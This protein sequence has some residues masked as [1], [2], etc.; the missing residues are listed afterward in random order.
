MKTAVHFTDNY[1]INPTNPILVNL[2]GVGGTGSQVLSAL[3]R[4]NVSLVKLGHPGLFVRAFDDDTITPANMGRQLFTES[5]IGLYKSV[6]IINRL[7]RF[8][9]TSW[10]AEPVKYDTVNIIPATKK[11]SAN[12]SISCVDTVKARFGIASLLKSISN[13]HNTDSV[14]RPIYWMD[15][16]NRQYTGQVILSTISPVKQPSSKKYLCAGSLPSVTEEFKDILHESGEEMESSCSL[17]EAL[18]KQ[19]LF[20]NSTLAA[21]GSSLLWKLFR[22]GM[23]QYRGFFLNLDD[24][25]TQPLPISVI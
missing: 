5:E 19:D 18:L 3:A 22:E 24:Y 20:I 4:I 1:L 16:G 15:Y 6:A 13:A 23:T 9:G 10:K 7:N 21:L 2:V 12:I 8:F 25:R 17:A 11:Y 14:D